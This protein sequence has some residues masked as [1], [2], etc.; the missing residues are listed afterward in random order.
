MEKPIH[1]HISVPNFSHSFQHL[2]HK[3][4]AQSYHKMAKLLDVHI[5]CLSSINKLADPE[6]N[7]LAR[8]LFPIV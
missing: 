6:Q 5:I 1:V 4:F 8:G 2:P 3:I 7:N